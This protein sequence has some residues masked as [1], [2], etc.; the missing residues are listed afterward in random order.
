MAYRSRTPRHFADG[1]L[2][3]E[4]KKMEGKQSLGPRMRFGRCEAIESVADEMLRI[5]MQGVTRYVDKSDILT[6]WKEDMRRRREILNSTGVA[7]PAVRKGIYGR[8]ANRDR[9]ELN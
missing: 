2:D 6:P 7:D 9:P 5:S 1:E 4:L 3:G 8:A